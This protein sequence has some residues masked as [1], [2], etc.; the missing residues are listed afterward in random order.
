MHEER[1]A[2]PSSAGRD[3]LVLLKELP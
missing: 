3:K 1:P 2:F